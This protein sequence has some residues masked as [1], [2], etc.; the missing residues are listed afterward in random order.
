MPP[1]PFIADFRLAVLIVFRSRFLL[2]LAT[3]STLLAAVVFLAGLFSPRQPATVSF[4]VGLSF[5]R[6]M[7]PCLLLLNVQEL[8]SREIDRK[9]ILTSLSYPRSRSLFLLARYF[10]VLFIASVQLF[11]FS[12]VLAVVVFFVGQGYAQSTQVSL[13]FPFLLTM[14]YQWLDVAVIAAFAVF[15]ASVSTTSNLVLLAGLGFLVIGRSASVVMSL[16]LTEG[17]HI[18]GAEWYQAA[19]QW[20]RWVI[21][22][23][24]AF[25][26]RS[27]ALYNK[28]ELL[29]FAPE[30]ALIMALAYVAFLLVIACV[31]FERR[32]FI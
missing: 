8:L 29:N 23:L 26:V 4:D 12:V 10:S 15:L 27:I 2:L 19:L 1:S 11:V 32:Q 18:K 13:G 7:V 22:D 25:D 24:A 17:A 16:L 9:L 21:P 6:F 30:R 20:T 3:L 5:I 28:I 14:V 31:R